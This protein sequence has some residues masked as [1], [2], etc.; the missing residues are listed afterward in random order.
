MV[1]DQI[2]KKKSTLTLSDTIVLLNIYSKAECGSFELFETM[3]KFIGR[4]VKSVEKD[5]VVSILTGFA[6]TE[7]RR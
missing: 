6:N 1:E 3:D 7:M 2:L 4:N 5:S